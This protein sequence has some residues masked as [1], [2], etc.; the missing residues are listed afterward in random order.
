MTPPFGLCSAR[1]NAGLPTLR[2]YR[3]GL[4]V[5]LLYAAVAHALLSPIAADWV[6]PVPSDFKPHLGTIVQARMALDEGQ[7]PPRV[8]PWQHNGWR[9][10]VFQFYSPLPYTL[11]GLVHGWVTPS[12]PYVAFKITVWLALV[13]AGIYTY[14]LASWLTG[15]RPAGLLTGAMYMAAPYFVMNILARGAFVEAVAQGILPAVL[16][17]SVRCYAEPGLRRF[18]PAAVCW[19][20]L[21]LVHTITWVYTSLFVGLWFVLLG[22]RPRKNL[23]RLL[24]LGAAYGLGCLLALYFLAPVASTDYLQI[25]TNLLDP[26]RYNWYTTLPTL[27]SPS[28]VAPEPQPGRSGGRDLHPAVGWPMLFA[29]AVMFHALL[30]RPSLLRRRA[31]GRFVPGLLGV[32]GLALFTTWSPIDFWA[33]L[34]SF[35][36]I[37]QIT[38]RMLTQ[39]MWPGAL[40]AAYAL[41]TVFG[42]RLD[43]RHVVVGLFLIGMGVSSYL[44]TAESSPTDLS[45]LIQQPDMG[46]GKDDYLMREERVLTSEASGENELPFIFTD[47]RLETE[48]DLALPDLTRFRSSPITLHVAG[49]IPPEPAPNPV[50]LSALLNDRK[51]ASGEFGAGP[52]EWDIPLKEPLNALKR[53]RDVKA[54]QLK[55]MTDISPS[56]ESKK[57][58]LSPEETPLMAVR[59]RSVVLRG[60]PAEQTALPVSRTQQS[61]SQR[62]LETFCSLSV[63]PEAGLVQLPVLFYPELLDVR[64]DGQAAPFLPLVDRTY[65]LVGLRLPPG[66][67]EISV[68]FEGLGWANRVSAVA[69]LGLAAVVVA[70]CLPLPAF[71]RRVRQRRRANAYGS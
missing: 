51:I 27:L 47:G 9:Y 8:A 50:H 21:A 68:R 43:A 58:D 23:G 45:L 2:R 14:R 39:V 48:R 5:A 24:R 19:C 55:L 61:C 41:V 29:W 33:Y 65:A 71:R 37:A 56:N 1:A 59:A 67:H 40:L 16:Y 17:Y 25:R 34:P 62:G 36:N 49:D 30:T 31:A 66:R 15:C 20:A 12:N 32:F 22:G 26:Y 57:R 70:S 69:W 10:P 46:Y 54:A 3:D 35:L 38:Y 53:G 60:L 6:V 64:V 7:F 42:R 18:V 11:A 28:S 13:L 52:F 63:P 4:L 44:P